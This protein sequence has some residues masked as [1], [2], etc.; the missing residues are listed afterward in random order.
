MP[1]YPIMDL[2]SMKKREGGGGEL[3][4]LLLRREDGPILPVFTSL[5]RFWAFVD[6]YYARDDS[7]RPT[8]V[9]MDPFKL[10]G[11]VR[12]IGGETVLKALVFD[13]IAL[14]G[15]KWRSAVKPAPI[16]TY[17]RFMSEIRPEVEKLA[18]ETEE[19]FGHLPDPVA[20]DDSLRWSK[21]LLDE[22]ADNAGARVEEWE[23]GDDS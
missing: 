21:P 20:F 18:K 14:T 2:S 5:N 6:K 8:T 15:G 9:P 1:Y 4:L 19:K 16:S 10:A 13:P 23:V 17:L 3:D 11:M 12:S 7:V 22:V